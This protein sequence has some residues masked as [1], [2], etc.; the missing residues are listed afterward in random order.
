M[1][2]I[3]KIAVC[4]V[5][6]NQIHHENICDFVGGCILA[7]KPPCAIAI[8]AQVLPKCN[9]IIQPATTKWLPPTLLNI[10]R[11]SQVHW[12]GRVFILLKKKPFQCEKIYLIV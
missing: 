8:L 5:V 7:L 9:P 1:I 4:V 6:A 2:T 3:C 11:K 10:D 12:E